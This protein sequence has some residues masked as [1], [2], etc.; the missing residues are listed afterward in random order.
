VSEKSIDLFIRKQ[1]P[2]ASARVD[3]FLPCSTPKILHGPSLAHND[4]LDILGERHS[5]G[6]GL[7]KE[8]PFDFRL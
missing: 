8:S 2:H 1:A 4:L 6:V 7:S 5:L 3:Q